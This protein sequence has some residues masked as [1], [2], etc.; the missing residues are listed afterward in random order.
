MCVGFIYNFLTHL[1]LY[2]AD[3]CN[4]I[5]V[6]DLFILKLYF[7]MESNKAAYIFKLSFVQALLF[8]SNY[9]LGLLI[10]KNIICFHGNNLLTFK[11]SNRKK[12]WHKGQAFVWVL[13]VSSYF[14]L[15]A[16]SD[17]TIVSNEKLVMRIILEI[18]K[19]LRKS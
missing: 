18:S 5:K 2:I 15:I 12:H 4:R 3:N 13:I 11:R 10:I 16:Q 8:L 17:T 14:I 1:W 6:L 19:I 7:Q 9:Y